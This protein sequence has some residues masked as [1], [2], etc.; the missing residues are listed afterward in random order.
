MNDDFNKL[1]DE[2]YHLKRDLKYTKILLDTHKHPLWSTREAE[3]I[4]NEKNEEISELTSLLEE[5][6][7]K[8]GKLLSEINDLRIK[9]MRLESR[10]DR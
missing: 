7:S 10:I 2:N 5:E 9:V 4:L 8:N 6:V 1:S 3:R